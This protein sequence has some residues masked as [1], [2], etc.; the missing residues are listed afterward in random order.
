MDAE[1]SIRTI[2]PVPRRLQGEAEQNN[3]WLSLLNSLRHV[4]KN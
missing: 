3:K 2:G 1:V 4:P